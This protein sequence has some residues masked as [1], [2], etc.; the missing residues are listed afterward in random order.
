MNAPEASQ[1]SPLW[2][3]LTKLAVGLTVIAIVAALMVRFRS[4]IGPLL[5]A[6]VL[7]YLLHP[8]ISRLSRF[9]HISWRISVNLIFLVVVV[10]FCS[11]IAVAGLNIIQQIQSLINFVRQLITDL[12]SILQALSTQVYQIGPLQ[13]SLAQYDVQALAN[14]I[15]SV[16]QPLLGRM[17]GLISSFAASAIT[18]FMWS[19]FVLIIAYFLLVDA[20]RV[21]SQLIVVEIPGYDADLRRL[22]VELRK[23][24]N[25]Y[26]RGQLIIIMMVIVVYT[27]LLTAFGVRYS[28]GIAILAGVAR[29]VPYIGTFVAWVTLGMVA[30]FQGSNYFGLE[31]YQYALLVVV[32]CMLVDQIFDNIISPRIFGDTLG[33]HPAAV[34]VA[35]I[36]ATNLI[37]V[38][39][40]VLAAPVLATFNL[41]GRYIFRKMFDLDPWPPL[42]SGAPY[43]RVPWM[44]GIRRIEAWLR[45]LK[46]RLRRSI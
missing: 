16:V 4:I 18:T 45:A 30:F 27:I 31:Q 24:W 39:G 34:L 25:A 8:I 7:S 1:K 3:P 13:F 21:S 9:S 22:G 41:V 38:I 23:V 43:A 17:G 12:P 33:V 28:L 40:L 15:L 44:R 37:G 14:Q 20:G 29:F 42:E 35:A 2:G 32:I 5:L 26:L 46:Q 11:L 6:F 19:L 10:I 36:V